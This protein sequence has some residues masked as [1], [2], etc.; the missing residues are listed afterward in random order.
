MSVL[1]TLSGLGLRAGG[2]DDDFRVSKYRQPSALLDRHSVHP[3]D[4][5]GRR[6]V[7]LAS[8]LRAWDKIVSIV[9]TIQHHQS[10]GI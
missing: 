8:A 2:A 6:V 10:D 1:K 4:G 3:A 7:S 5:C 9:S